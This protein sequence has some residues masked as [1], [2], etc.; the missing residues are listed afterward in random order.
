MAGAGSCMA[1]AE[2]SN[3]GEAD[4][5]LARF[6]ATGP[7]GWSAR[8]G[9]TIEGDNIDLGPLPPPRD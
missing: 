2:C 7:I 1:A 8:L 6:W 5:K 3:S 4:D 9:A